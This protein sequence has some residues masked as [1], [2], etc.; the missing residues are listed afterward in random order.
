M[1]DKDLIQLLQ[2]SPLAASVHFILPLGMLSPLLAGLLIISFIHILRK[3]T[4]SLAMLLLVILSPA[5]FQEFMFVRGQSFGLARFY[6]SFQLAGLLLMMYFHQTNSPKTRLAVRLGAVIL[7]ICGIFTT[8]H[9]MNPPEQVFFASFRS[10]KSV[11]AFAQLISNEAI[12]EDQFAL[13]IEVAHIFRERF[14]RQDVLILVDTQS[15]EVVLY[16]QIPQRFILP[17][18]YDYESILADPI[19]A[20]DYILVASPDRERMGYHALL[21]HYPDLY[22]RGI[23]GF[24][25]DTKIGDF[26]LYRNTTK[27]SG[28]LN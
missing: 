12:I 21:A 2:K 11:K 28:G 24:V 25:L 20:A 15:E 10:D 18:D 19:F 7:L 13:D 8:L 4:I 1:A 23:P 22:A 3:R 6:L 16:S 5:L 26:R 14:A 17:S 27:K 9:I